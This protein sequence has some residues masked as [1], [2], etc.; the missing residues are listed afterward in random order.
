MVTL[1]DS[2]FEKI[3]P[4]FIRIDK[5][6]RIL[7]SGASI[8]KVVGDV[9]GRPFSEV[10]K[11]ISPSMSIRNEF[12]SLK[13]HQDI[14]VIL[15]SVEF[16]LKTR[17]RGQFIHVP[18]EDQ[19]VYLNSPWI[20]D[21]HD[22]S[23]HNLLISD[24]A[25]HDTITDN[26]QLLKSKEIMFE[27]M[28]KIA[29]EVIIQRN[30]LI[31]KNE[32][33]I[34]L[35][36]FPDQN[37]Q[38]ILRM[39]FEGR[40]MY[41]NDHASEL[42]VSKSLLNLPF[43]GTIY[44]RFEANGY[45]NYE[46][47]FL[48][49]DLVFHATLV[50]I[51]EKR[52]FNIYLRD[53]TKTV[54]FQYELMSTSSRLHTLIRSMHS[55]VLAEN[56]N[57]EIILVNQT[58][59]DLFMIPLDPDSMNGMDCSQ[60]LENSK[61]LF[62]DSEGF[63][64]R[65]DHILLDKK[66][67]DGDILKMK[68][69]KI[70]EL[71]YLPIYE[72]GE[73]NGHI[74]KYQ[75][76]TTLMHN[77]ESLRKV[78]DK[79]RKIIE[80]LEVGLIE[81]DLEETI[82]KVYPAFCQMTGYSE[83][84]LLGT[85]ARILLAFDE[86]RLQLNKQNALRKKGVSGVFETRIKTKEGEIKWVIISGAPIFDESDKIVGS[87][88]VHVDITDRKKLE[89]DLIEANKKALS[90]VKMKEMFVANISH[91]IR[92]PMNVIIGMLDLITD[93][94]LNYEQNKY[95]NTI[96]RSADALLVLLNDL[97]DFSKIEAGQLTIEMT[98]TNIYN[99]F[100]HIQYSFG[101]K[102]KAKG[103]HLISNVDSRIFSEVISDS[104]KLN[105]V[106]VNLVSNAVKFTD[107]GFVK[108]SAILISEDTENQVIHF[109]V[110]DSGV[111]IAEENLES[112]FQIFIQEDSSVSRKYGGTGLGLSISREIITKLGGEINVASEKGKGS[113]FSFELS[114][115][116]GK[117]E[118]IIHENEN[119]EIDLSAVSVLVAEDNPLNQTLIK[120]ILR[121]KNITFDLVENGEEVLK[122]LPKKN[123]DILLIDIQMPVMDGITA[124][125]H[126]REIMRLKIPIVALTA[127]ASREDEKLYRS[128]GMDGYLAKPYRK[129]DLF[130]IINE[131]VI[132]K[133]EQ[134]LEGDIEVIEPKKDLYSLD[135][136]RNISEGDEDFVLSII[137]TF[138]TNTPEH[139]KEIGFGLAKDDL[140]KVR[141]FAHQ[142]KP[143]LDILGITE[144]SVLVRE[145]EVQA[146]KSQPDKEQMALSYNQLKD[147]IDQVIID[148]YSKF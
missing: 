26:L 119:I 76:I 102:A 5:D 99:L 54:K 53:I 121:Q 42:I 64:K 39:D 90:S 40:V 24:F 18:E 89:E 79:Y 44:L 106:F 30:E 50:P 81:V 95:L 67:V 127:N 13:D 22:L 148:F 100:E 86:D 48:L 116:K 83:R 1:N 33:I 7:T 57:R 29:D 14:I 46:K 49:G 77:K 137:D 96:K 104:S 78:E 143:S 38:P 8:R 31:D 59:C 4:F 110:E 135:E 131:I 52:Y 97:L 117:L 41:A 133:K 72:E 6:M 21:V 140:G 60:A 35:A 17:F 105:Q 61:H 92:T 123:Y 101:E 28:K 36:R 142:L 12:N 16:P 80:N 103:I 68:N 138:R 134:K 25:V 130:R 111:G 139:M 136:I 145:L 128:I 20:T 126:I 23:F 112:V 88:G 82:T 34:E 118:K 85:N 91:E 19:I 87:L 125:K 45:N 141:K 2:I 124:A 32:T 109:S 66:R 65:I 94:N 47:E 115:K 51:K 108:L 69:G 71:D 147:I 43:W 58:F 98:N 84:E 15:E 11:F 120:S 74:W 62:E 114:L 132:L 3:F 93:D 113:V 73:Y 27:D 75:D 10:F 70:V 107:K 144:G 55:A 9:N 129:E 146:S 56:T 122:M 37:P 63:V